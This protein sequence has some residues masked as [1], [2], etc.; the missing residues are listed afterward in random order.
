MSNIQFEDSNYRAPNY[1]SSSGRGM[2]NWLIQKGLVKNEAAAE[3]FLLVV[4]LIFLGISIFL[5]TSSN[6][7]PE[8]YIDDVGPKETFVK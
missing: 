7:T 5:Y 2:A 3:I 1:S 8:S 4:A 6:N